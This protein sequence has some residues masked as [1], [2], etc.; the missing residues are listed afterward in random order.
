MDLTQDIFYLGWSFWNEKEKI[1]PEPKVFTENY[2]KIRRGIYRAKTIL[3]K[4]SI[5]EK[6]KQVNPNHS[7][8]LSEEFS[9]FKNQVNLCLTF[10]D[11][12]GAQEGNLRKAYFNLR[13]LLEVS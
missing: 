4:L 9:N 6:L 5:D 10:P 13:L 11:V 7:M 3:L 2:L 12:F 1:L 8:K